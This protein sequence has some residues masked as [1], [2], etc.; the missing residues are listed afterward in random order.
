[1]NKT[2]FL[3]LAAA[4]LAIPGIGLRALHLLN[5]F[6]VDTGLPTAD[7]PWVWVCTA[8]FALCAV[9]YGVLAAPLRE[10]ENTPFERLFGT[11]NTL[12]RMTT[13]IAAMLLIACSA[14]YLYFTFTADTDN[15][16]M[17]ARILEIVYS[18]AGIGSGVCMIAFTKAQSAAQLTS[19][20][21]KCVL[22]LLFW[23]AIHL[24]VNYRMTCTDPRLPLFGFGLIAD[25]VLVLAVYHFARMLYGRPQPMLLA[26]FGGLA[27]TMSFSDLGGYGLA[28]LMGVTSVGW[29]A[30]MLLRSGLSAAA[31]LY[32]LAQLFVLCADHTERAK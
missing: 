9:L 29:S 24:L 2:K 20:P 11:E 5:G 3:P 1:M 16:S 23:S 14:G 12:F 10:Q 18:L 31:C 13:V 28:R 26:L 27:V 25:V 17:W 22:L 30:Q 4:A 6:D 19:E 32:V 15:F 21:A 8:F 7:S